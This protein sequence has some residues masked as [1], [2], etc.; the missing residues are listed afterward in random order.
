MVFSLTSQFAHDARSQKPKASLQ[1][2]CRATARW[3]NSLRIQ[4]NWVNG[5]IVVTKCC[6]RSGHMSKEGCRPYASSAK[7]IGKAKG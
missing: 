3:S 4:C 5:L 2:V 6:G 7:Q 1:G